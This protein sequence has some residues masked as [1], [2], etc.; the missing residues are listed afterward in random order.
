MKK[1]LSVLCVLVLIAGLA[2]CGKGGDASSSGKSSSM[3]SSKTASGSVTK[4]ARGFDRDAI[5][6]AVAY[7]KKNADR[8]RSLSKETREQIVTATIKGLRSTGR[9]LD[10]DIKYAEQKFRTLY[11]L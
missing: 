6:R 9:Y 8:Y 7:M 2:A 4:G 3:K 11:G 10:E 1:V 5:D